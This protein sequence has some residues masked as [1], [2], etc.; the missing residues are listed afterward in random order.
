MHLFSNAIE[1]ALKAEVVMWHEALHA[2]FDAMYG[3]RSKAYY[4]AL[5]ETVS[6]ANATTNTASIG[7]KGETTRL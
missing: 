5:L 4:A 6:E 1:G 2:G 7:I 3:G